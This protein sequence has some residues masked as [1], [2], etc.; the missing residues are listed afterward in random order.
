[1]SD[2]NP[3]RTLLDLNDLIEKTKKDAVEKH[4]KKEVEQFWGAIKKVQIAVFVAAI[5]PFV[6][7]GVALGYLYMVHYFIHLPDM[8]K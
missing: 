1:M 7:F 3:L 4:E 8:I 5:S 2:S 6:G